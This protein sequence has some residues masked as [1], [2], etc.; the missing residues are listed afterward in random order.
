M[1]TRNLS[2]MIL[3]T[4]NEVSST[5]V[6]RWI[7]H[8]IGYVVSLTH[9]LTQVVLTSKRFQCRA[10]TPHAFRQLCFIGTERNAQEAFALAA[11]RRRWNCHDALLQ[12]SLSDAQFIAI[13]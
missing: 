9:P 1:P 7:D 10:Q 13:P 11:K 8:S 4:G 3:Q 2:D 6:S 5:C 12:S